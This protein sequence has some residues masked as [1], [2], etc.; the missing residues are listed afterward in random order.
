MQ[1][2]D[3]TDGDD[4]VF[5]FQIQGHGTRCV[6][7]GKEYFLTADFSITELRSFLTQR[8]KFRSFLRRVVLRRGVQRVG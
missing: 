2:A 5:T 4:V 3:A 7:P 6:G 8:F 1:K